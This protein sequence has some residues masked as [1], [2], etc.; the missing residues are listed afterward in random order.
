MQRHQPRLE[1]EARDQQRDGHVA[2]RRCADG[3][4]HIGDGKALAGR[5]GR[6]EREGGEQR[7]LPQHREQHIQRAGAH[8]LR[9]AVVHHQAP[10]RQAGQCEGQVES[11]Q[12][13]RD[14]NAKAAR[15]R[16]QP[17]GRE[18]REA[19]PREVRPRIDPRR[20]PQQRCRTEQQ[21]PRRI[22]RDAEPQPRIQHQHGIRRGQRGTGEAR[23][24]R[25]PDQPRRAVAP[26]RHRHGRQQQQRHQ[27]CGQQQQRGHGARSS[28]PTC[29]NPKAASGSSPS[30]T[31]TTA[32]ASTIFSRLSGRRSAGCVPSPVSAPAITR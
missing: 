6:Q 4:Q 14:E 9:A 2:Q 7:G 15:Q 28:R 30:T 24:R 11:N 12:V 25:R 29:T 18:A 5:R 19:R 32:S 17:P 1:A 31:E 27:R 10:G 13:R 21:G 8:G 26:P 16:R 23:Q 22:E 20:A 3:G